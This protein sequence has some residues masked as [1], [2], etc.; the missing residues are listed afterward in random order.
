[1]N[2]ACITDREGRVQHCRMKLLSK[3]L[4]PVCTYHV[5][6]IGQVPRSLKKYDIVYYSHFSLAERFP[7]KGTKYCSVT[8][9]KCLKEMKKTVNALKRFKRVSVNNTILFEKFKGIIKHLYYTPNGVDRTKFVFINKSK[10]KEMCLGWVGNADR[11]AKNFKTIINP[12][13]KQTKGFKFN[14]IP[15]SKKDKG[16][17]LKNVDQMCKY[18]QSLDFFLVASS[19]EGTPNPGLEALSCGVPVITT[20]VGNM[21]EV[22]QDGK[23]GFFVKPSV[24]EFTSVLNRMRNLSDEEYASMRQEANISMINWD[25]S[26]KSKEWV[27]FLAE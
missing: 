13:R 26:V 4:D 19:S 8:S 1:M 7:F 18:Y 6:H 27:K 21:I 24:E 3:Y 16:R 17:S 22:I 20:R 11:K 23:N 10:G 9:H 15:T 25:W 14:I 2:I 12:L 5:Y